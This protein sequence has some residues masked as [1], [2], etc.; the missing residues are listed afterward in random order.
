MSACRQGQVASAGVGGLGRGAKR[1]RG[2]MGK[3]EDSIVL[4]FA[5]ATL[6]KIVK[7]SYFAGRIKKLSGPHMASRL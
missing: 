7:Y 4:V 2:H 5:L 3:S 6:K 1:P